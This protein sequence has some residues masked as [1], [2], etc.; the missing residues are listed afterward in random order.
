MRNLGV[1]YQIQKE[2]HAL[3]ESINIAFTTMPI[4]K[5][6]QMQTKYFALQ[7]ESRHCVFTLYHSR[8]N[9][10]WIR[11]FRVK[12]K[13]RELL[14]DEDGMRNYFLNNSLTAQT[15]K[16]KTG[17]KVKIPQGENLEVIFYTP[18]EKLLKCDKSAK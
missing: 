5:I 7:I 10:R 2:G 4:I 8:I 13:C 9:S 16:A 11:D 14:E 12:G 3:R 17:R 18:Q 6:L 15:V 1:I